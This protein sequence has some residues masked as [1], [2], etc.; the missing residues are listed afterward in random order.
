MKLTKAKLRQVIKEEVQRLKE[1]DP[2]G[3]PPRPGEQGSADETPA[4]LSYGDAMTRVDQIMNAID[5]GGVADDAHVTDLLA[6]VGDDGSFETDEARAAIMALQDRDGG[7]TTGD[8][9]G[10][11]RDTLRAQGR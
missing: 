3:D 5:Q 10:Y 6:V 2:Y 9:Y 11:I 7:T 1:S 4:D 8:A